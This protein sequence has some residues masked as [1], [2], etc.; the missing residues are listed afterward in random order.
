MQMVEMDSNVS[1]SQKSEI[2]Y[3]EERIR[4]VI[5]ETENF[6]NPFNEEDKS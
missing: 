1:S 2:M 3:S 6:I 5:D 4:K